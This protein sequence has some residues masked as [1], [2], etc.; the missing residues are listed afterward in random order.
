MHFGPRAALERMF[1]PRKKKPEYPLQSTTNG[2][3]IPEESTSLASRPDFLSADFNVLDDLDDNTGNYRVF[4][5]LD[6]IVTA[7]MRHREERRIQQSESPLAADETGPLTNPDEDPADQPAPPLLT[8]VSRGRTLI[9]DTNLQRALGCCKQLEAGGLTCTLCI[10]DGNTTSLSFS[11]S[12]SHP[13]FKTDFL[14]VYG[15]FGG[16]TVMT[17]NGGGQLPLSSHLGGESDFFDLVLDMQAS[18]SYHGSMIP[19]GYYAPGEEQSLIEEALNELPAMRG[20]FAKP[21]FTIYQEK[22]CL[23][24]RSTD[25]D[26]R[27]CLD[28]CPVGAISSKDRQLVFDHYLCQGCGGCALVCPADALQLTSPAQDELLSD[29]AGLISSAHDRG[30]S[31]PRLVIYDRDIENLA[32]GSPDS[33]ATHPLEQ[34]ILFGVD[35]IGRVGLEILLAALAYGAADITLVC[36]SARPP[37]ILEALEGQV[38]LGRII[39]QG[40]D[41][42]PDRI[43]L[44]HRGEMVASGDFFPERNGDSAAAVELPAP[45]ASFPP[46]L[47]KRTLI[48]MAADHLARMTGTKEG[49][50]VL[51]AQTPFGTIRIDESACS[52]CM[53]CV[54]SC[55]SAALGASGNIP[56][57]TML[58]SRCHQ[59]GLCEALCPE[60]AIRL[61]SG[62]LWD[63]EAADT[64]AIMLEVEPFHCIECGEPFSSPAMV[65]RMQEKLSGHWMYSSDRQKR[66]LQM[67]RICRTRDA[68]TAGDYR[69]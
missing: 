36:G 46:G 23:H 16:F 6:G 34:R 17:G 22:R 48:R 53:A 37:A 58:E 13:I 42:P 21:Q 12:G 40:L 56:R 20:R 7:D 10:Q 52:L 31:A 24:G 8:I 69:A 62:L 54:G 41:L 64:P 2:S 45:P 55:P 38:Q 15:S 18:P 33:P 59:C 51:P 26:C 28:I 27:R 3:R 9:I 19:A 60:K 67:C 68:L 66:R 1:M 14:A 43:A 50:I 47:D 30:K 5:S 29:I 49:T 57:I 11:R 63:V 32:A 44:V 65:T 39:L 25:R 35:E 4:D 61:Q